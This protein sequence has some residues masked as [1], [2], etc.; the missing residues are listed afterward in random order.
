MTISQKVY[1]T[2]Q[3]N[4]LNFTYMP[5]FKLSDDE[6]AAEMGISRTPVREALNRLLQQ[7]LVVGIPNKGFR[8]KSFTNKEIEDLYVVRENLECLAVKLT[9]KNMNSKIEKSLKSTLLDYQEMID[10]GDLVGANLADTN[11]HDVIALSSGNTFLHKELS[12]L[13]NQIQIIRRYDHIRLNSG[14][15][16]YNEHLQIL[17]DMIDGDIPKA[18]ESMSYHIMKSLR[19]ILKIKDRNGQKILLNLKKG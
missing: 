15:N 11:F 16:T 1:E 3:K 19:G 13:S 4:I 9:I 6:I 12:D 2:I 14:V 8:V 10:S 17:K 18:V 5:G 7:G